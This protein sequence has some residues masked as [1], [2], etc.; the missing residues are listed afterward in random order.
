MP[1]RSNDDLLREFL[2]THDASCPVCGYGLRGVPSPV[3]PECAAPLHLE[4]ASV[5]GKTGPWLVALGAWTL[6]LGFDGVVALI[7]TIGVL[8]SR[9]PLSQLYPYIWAGTFLTLT[10]GGVIGLHG[11]LGARGR[12]GIKPRRVQWRDAV[13]TIIAVGGVHLAVGVCIVIIG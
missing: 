8:I 9:P 3:C 13:V 2:A 10:V 6:S 7:M 1:D 11:V 4:I 12:W 5:Q